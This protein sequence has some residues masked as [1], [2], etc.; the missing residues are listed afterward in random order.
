MYDA[1]T[2]FYE[3]HEFAE[4]NKFN[5][6]A[7]ENGLG[8]TMVWLEGSYE[9]IMTIDLPDVQVGVQGFTA[10][11][12]DSEGNTWIITLDINIYNPIEKYDVLCNHNLVILAR[13]DGFSDTYHVPA[14]ILEKAFDRVTGSIIASTVYVV[15]YQNE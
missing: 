6:P 2:N 5:S 12:T 4:F 13:Y 10:F 7:S 14:V 1:P 11:V 3:G 15:V 8:G 9:N